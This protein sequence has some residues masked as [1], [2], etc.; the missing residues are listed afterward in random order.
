MMVGWPQGIYLAL[1]LI[2]L[3]VAAAK[4][5]QPKTGT[6]SFWV[7]LPASAILL[8]LLAWGGFFG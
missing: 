2:G 4:H 6:Y 3:G 7:S 1:V 8:G 5:G